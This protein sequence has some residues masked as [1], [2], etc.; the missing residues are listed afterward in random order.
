M[1]KGDP[2]EVDQVPLYD[3]KEGLEGCTRPAR[4]PYT[5]DLR[6]R[7]IVVDNG[8]YH[9]RVGWSGEEN[10]RIDFRSVYTKARN[11]ASGESRRLVGDFDPAQISKG[12][13]LSRLQMRSPFDG[14]IV[15][16]F[17]TQE[18]LL[19]FAFQKMSLG[20]SKER[21]VPHPVLITETLCNPSYCRSKTAETLF[22]VY[23]V[24][25]IEF[26]H[27]MLFSDLYNRSKG[28][29]T[30]EDSLL[31][32]SGH[33]ATFVLP[34]L[35]G[36]PTF[37][38]ALRLDVGGMHLTTHLLQSL[39]VH[40]PA[41]SSTF[42]W[43]NAEHIKH[44]HCYLP[45]D[46]DAEL[47]IFQVGGQEA[48]KR[49]V[50]IQLPWQAK[51]GESKSSNVDAEEAAARKAEQREKAAA[52]LRQMA[53]QKKE[54]KIKELETTVQ[55][56]ENIEENVSAL[57]EDETK[58]IL[59]QFGFSGLAG[60]AAALIDAKN[61]L[62]RLQ[63]KSL[64]QPEVEIK[65][66]DPTK[67][68]PLLS[69]PDEQL[70]EED[71]R[72]K[73]RQRLSKNAED[74]RKRK[75]Q[76]KALREAEL[77]EAR[78]KEDEEYRNDPV[79]FLERLRARHRELA[80][81]MEAR[82]NGR[83]TEEKSVVMSTGRGARVSAAQRERMK[84]MAEAAFG[85]ASNEDAFGASDADWNV[86][87]EMDAGE[88]DEEAL[89][90]EEAE[91][92]RTVARLRELDP[93][94]VIEWN[95]TS[96]DAVPKESRMPTAEDYQIYLTVERIKIPEILFQPHL[97][98]VDQVGIGEM[99]SSCFRRLEPNQRTKL[100]RAPLH[101]TGGNVLFPGFKERTFREFRALRDPKHEPIVSI[102]LDP[103]LDAWR[104]ASL[105][106]SR[107]SGTFGILREE[108]EEQGERILLSRPSIQYGI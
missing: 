106:S 26:G 67:K 38:G 58:V 88:E 83:T 74:G 20:E 17:E 64:P 108:Y 45:E 5:E 97:C 95:G 103:I 47:D 33:S 7:T 76:E 51:Q 40:Y 11:K 77:L 31:V 16:N 55:Q 43:F 62:A 4:T 60:I 2:Y 86:Y 23:G 81:R 29:W 8:S 14:D 30:G 1:T 46:Y 107:S 75:A 34:I 41:V 84:L 32:S 71:L 66:E 73:K 82:K 12:W 39:T 85:R 50:R 68:Y 56:L 28:N 57:G 6:D 104:G 9:C 49:T 18:T 61:T 93:S 80:D 25:S 3:L 63:G 94:S 53:A 70:S 78:K 24:N 90:E 98:G 102:A 100:L 44:T 72:E 15:S 19:D 96:K 54:A 87:K 22:E 13:E 101:L 105:W 99:I 21:G 91:F 36:T 37:E 92:E 48:Q 65:E 27:D 42:N 89:A 79:G 10:P 69:V 59:S 35:G 52:R